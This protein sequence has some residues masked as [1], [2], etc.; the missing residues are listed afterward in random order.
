MA[1]NISYVYRAVDKFSPIAKKIKDNV[2]ELKQKIGNTSQ[3][4]REFGT[5][6]RNTGAKLTAFATIPLVFLGNRMIKAASDAEEMRARF[7]FVFSDVS[8]NAA[9]SAKI[10]GSSYNFS[11]KE[12]QEFLANLGDFAQNL[13]FSQEKSLELSFEL[14]K[15][16]ADVASFKNVQGGA[17]Q[18]SRAFQSAL[19]GERESL[20]TLGVAINEEMV[21]NQILVMSK[22]GVRFETMMQA[23]ALATIELL[24]K[25]FSSSIGDVA[26][27]QDAHANT[28]RRYRARLDDASVSIGNYLIPI[29]LK[30]AEITL[31][32]LK[33]FDDLSP[34]L[35]KTILIIAG[36]VAALGPLLLIIGTLVIGFGLLLTPIGLTVAA[37]GGLIAIGAMLAI[38]YKPVFDFLRMGFE[39]VAL[40]VT[41]FI[42]GL[43]VVKDIISDLMPDFEWMSKLAEKI[44]GMFGG[45]GGGMSSIADRL[46][47]KR[48]EINTDGNKSNVNSSTWN[49]ATL[50]GTIIVEALGNSRIVNTKMSQKGMSG[51]LGMSMPQGAY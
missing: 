16:A 40:T 48:R 9:N 2:A 31:K 32:L 25:N 30:L 14:N 22:R 33:V 6:I 5:S 27:T 24:H 7:E 12:A 28:M 45:V 42:N 15:L 43:K 10:L 19:V 17:S 29:Q 13:G 47:E 35:K 39:V 51:N 38:K 4:M 36:L 23:K 8:K 46:A 1:F 21:K 18:V 3:S 41:H 11:N 26:R 50:D 20:K 34:Q 37:I 49:K 44:G